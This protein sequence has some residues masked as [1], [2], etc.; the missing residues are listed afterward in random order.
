MDGIEDGEEWRWDEVKERLRSERAFE[1]TLG[2]ITR[3]PGLKQLS[4][5]ILSRPTKL[6]QLLSLLQDP[7]TLLFIW[8]RFELITVSIDCKGNVR[9]HH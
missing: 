4:C 1:D 8:C 7:L 2:A 3:T 9:L 5:E 6:A